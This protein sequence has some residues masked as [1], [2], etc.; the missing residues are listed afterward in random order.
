MATYRPRDH[1]HERAKREGYAARS[2]YKLEEIDRKLRLIAPGARVLDLGAAPGSWT[3][4]ASRA[5]GERGVV[6]AVDRAPLRIR[7]PQN[8]RAITADALSVEPASLCA[9]VG[10]A[11]FDIVLSDMA[12]RTSGDRFVDQQRSA[13][14]CGRALWLARSTL[15]PGGS[16]VAKVLEGESTRDFVAA[17]RAEFRTVRLVRPEATRKRSTE[18]FVIGMGRVAPAHSEEG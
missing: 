1:F 5:V 6:V 14:L 10:G 12:P 16:F 7:V 11:R 3:Q 17:V 8:V 2:A 4:Y 9:A 18:V 13:D 15:R